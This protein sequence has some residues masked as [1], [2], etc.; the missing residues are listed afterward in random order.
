[1]KEEVLFSAHNLQK[2][3]AVP[4]LK[5]FSFELKRGEV[6]ALMGSNG[7]GKSTFCNI[8]AGVLPPTLG[9]MTFIGSQYTPSSIADSESA[10]IYMVM[11]E[12]NLFPTL[13]IAE[14]IFFKSLSSRFGVIDH[15]KLRE[16]AA[17]V[18]EKVGLGSM[19]PALPLSS[20]GVG[21]QQLVEI[22]R[23]LI[24]PI[25]L[26]I[27]D[28]PTA[29]LTDPQIEKLFQQID[30]LK[31]N[32]VGIIYISHRM[33]EIKRISDRVSIL[34]D[35]ELISTQDSASTDMEDVAQLMVGRKNFAKEV[36]AHAQHSSHT[37]ELESK[38]AAAAEAAGKASLTIKNFSREGAF[39]NI[40]FT[41]H[42][43]EILGL[44]GLIGSGRT[45]LLRAIFGADKADNGELFFS[46]HVFPEHGAKSMTPF[47]TPRQAMD[48]GIGMV[49][50]DRKSEGL[51]L[52][53]SIKLNSNLIAL[54]QLSST[55]G[56][57]SEVKEELSAKELV[58]ELVTKYD[59]LEQPVCSLSGGNQQKVLISRWLALRFPI[60]LF[61]EPT[62]GVDANAKVKIHNLI[63]SLADEGRSILVI[64]SETQE[65]FSLCDRLLVM[66]NG[67]IS[68]EFDSANI[69]EQAW[70]AACFINYKRK[71]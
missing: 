45:E 71:A 40:S 38:T 33:D 53:Q 28:E 8:I 18:L 69:D 66:S 37:D 55:L 39:K 14:N 70:H 22:A 13:S 41:M 23:V 34:R 61:D 2:V 31:K 4:V 63:R 26:L 60:L 56:I 32:G 64:S 30:Q 16:K 62:R 27:L 54:N 46:D 6:H 5:N 43:G 49:V 9:D 15:Q 65:L 67:S 35:G 29:A 47:T 7:A 50:E 17:L 36:T 42:R 25:K 10:G 59:S 44:G 21:Q 1:M 58:E 51:F 20:L 12:L 11:Q 19:D 57:L 68:A 52:S 3:F 24:E 48:N